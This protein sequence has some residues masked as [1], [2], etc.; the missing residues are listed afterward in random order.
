M[1][2]VVAVSEASLAAVSVF[3]TLV[4]SDELQLTNLVNTDMAIYSLV[5]QQMIAHSN[6]TGDASIDVCTLSNG[7]YFVR[8]QNGSAVRTEKIAIVR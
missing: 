4:T 6:V 8:I 3:P 1:Q 2:N 7:I 5:G